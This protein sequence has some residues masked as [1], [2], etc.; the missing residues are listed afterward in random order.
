[1]PCAHLVPCH[2]SAPETD[3]IKSCCQSHLVITCGVFLSDSR[4]LI[5]PGDSLPVSCGVQKYGHAKSLSRQPWREVMPQDRW[6]LS[7][8]RENVITVP[9]LYIFIN[10][11]QIAIRGNGTPNAVCYKHNRQFEFIVCTES[12]Y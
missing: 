9:A 7:A 10:T 11:A 1:M 8:A 2:L 5:S 6:K 12:D 4:E 3:N